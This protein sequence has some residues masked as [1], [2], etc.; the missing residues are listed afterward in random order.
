[1]QQLPFD[2][3][4]LVSLQEVEFYG[5]SALEL[6]KDEHVNLAVSRLTALIASSRSDEAVTAVAPVVEALVEVAG[7]TNVEDLILS[8]ENIDPGQVKRSNE[9]ATE[10]AKSKAMQHSVFFILLLRVELQS[11]T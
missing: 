4:M 3:L 1:M 6:V 9:E 7:F 10:R 5:I 2:A 8:N 11:M